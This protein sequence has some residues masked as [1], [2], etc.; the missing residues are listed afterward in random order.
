MHINFQACVGIITLRFLEEFWQN[1][2]SLYN[3]TITILY[4]IALECGTGSLMWYLWGIM[5]LHF[6]RW[7]H[8]LTHVTKR[9][10]FWTLSYIFTFLAL[11]KRAC[12]AYVSYSPACSQASGIKKEAIEKLKTCFGCINS[13]SCSYIKITIAILGDPALWIISLFCW[14]L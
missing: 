2:I 11:N 8:L 1:W 7:P 9:A 13:S 4:Q 12:L 14:H 10:A 5:K 3:I 6:T